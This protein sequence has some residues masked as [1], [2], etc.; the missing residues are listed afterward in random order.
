MTLHSLRPENSWHIRQGGIRRG[1]FDKSP[2]CADG[3]SLA[4]AEQRFQLRER[5]FNWVHIGRVR[6]QKEGLAAHGLTAVI[7]CAGR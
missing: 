6:L 3:S 2:E 5:H 4:F 7:L 1:A